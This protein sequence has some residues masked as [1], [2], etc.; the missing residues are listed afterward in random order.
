[1]ASER[2][3]IRG[4]RSWWARWM[5]GLD[6]SL[7]MR[8]SNH[9]GPAPGQVLTWESPVFSALP[10]RDSDLIAESA[11]GLFAYAAETMIPV[12]LIPQDQV[13]LAVKGATDRIFLLRGTGRNLEGLMTPEHI[14]FAKCLA[15]RLLAWTSRLP[16]KLEIQPRLPGTGIV[17]HCHPDLICGTELIEV[18]MSR[19]MFRIPDLQQ[20]LVYSALAWL[21]TNRQ[22]ERVTLTNPMLGV[23]WSFELRA[24]I[25]EI[26]GISSSRFFDQFDE[27]SRGDSHP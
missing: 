26:S 14:Q 6:A 5:P 24:L 7:M 27:M 23:A 11:F 17:D 12:E 13:L 10:P 22:I 20:L 16:G 21:G 25:R 9:E 19:T 8:M 18:K 1:M 2:Q 4:H 15:T 3:L